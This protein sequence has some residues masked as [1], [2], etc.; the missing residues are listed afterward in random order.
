MCLAR[1]TVVIKR[2]PSEG[3]ASL[4][5]RGD[6]TLASEQARVRGGRWRDDSQIAVWPQGAQP[7]TAASVTPLSQQQQREGCT[8]APTRGV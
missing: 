2:A 1:I 4:P 5:A 8:I 3:G 6:R 7:A